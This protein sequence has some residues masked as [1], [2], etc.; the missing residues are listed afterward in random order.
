M[1]RQALNPILPSYEYI[2]DAEPRVFGDRL[3]L[4]G[5]H[6]KFNGKKFCMNDYVC[7]SAPVKDLS[8]W[9]Y[10]GILYR[11]N[12]DPMNPNGTHRLYAPDVARGPDG[13]YYLYYAF[14]LMGV[15]GVAVCDSPAG[16]YEFYGHV[17][18]PD[19]R[20]L[21]GQKK[22]QF[23]FDPGAFVDDDGKI[24]L[25]SG[26]APGFNLPAFL[27][28]HKK[29]YT[30]GAFVMELEE[31]MKTVKG[32]PK[33]LFGQ[34]Q[35]AVGTEFE[36]HSFFEAG[37]MRKIG[38][39][40]YFIYSSQNNHE[41]CYTLGASPM[42]PFRFGG[43]LVSIGD[44]FPHR[45]DHLK[46]ALNF[47]GNT[48]GSIVEIEGQRYVFYHRQTN[49]HMFSRQAMAEKIDIDD[50]GN[51]LQAELTSCGLNDGYLKGRGEYDAGIACHLTSRKGTR[52]YSLYSKL[53]GPFPYFTQS[54]EDRED[55]PDQYIANMRDGSTAGFKYFSIKN[56]KEI[57]VRVSSPKGGAMEVSTGPGEPPFAVIPLSPSDG[58][59]TCSVET[60]LPDGD[61]A[62]YF[63][64]RGRGVL[65]FHRFRLA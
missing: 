35:E 15:I 44:I 19:G 51:I 59:R 48:H 63:R 30:D 33:R 25:Y 26:F 56:L 20:V 16:A 11:K 46:K 53:R 7:W 65:N 42:G 24:Y 3:Y 55:H 21:G 6:D 45:K 37:S 47:T 38:G 18:H 40:Y 36:G 31:D 61:H 28:Q 17:S 23:Q 54:G 4:F 57:G 41:L 2:P 27:T 14:D 64:F 29:R 13:R 58:V 22:S 9:R 43:T 52:K 39:R 5:S 10:E 62:L 1:K 34:P 8:D 60:A 50:D 49:R 32:E 12:Q